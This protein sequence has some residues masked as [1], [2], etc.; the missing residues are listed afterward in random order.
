MEEESKLDIQERKA[1]YVFK[2]PTFSTDH[3]IDDNT[4]YWMPGW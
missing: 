3:A 1:S 4:L 2:S